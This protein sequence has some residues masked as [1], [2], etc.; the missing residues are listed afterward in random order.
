MGKMSRNKGARSERAL[1]D[2][3]IRRNWTNVIRV[4][5][6]GAVKTRDA[7][8]DDVVGTPPGW[9]SEIRFENKA[10]S[11]GFESIYALLNSKTTLISFSVHNHIVAVMS[12][13]PTEI[14]HSASKEGAPD[15]STFDI[16]TQKV[17]K[18][19]IKK[20]EMWIGTAQVLSLKLDRHPFLFIRYYR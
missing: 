7:Y 9:D 13:D 14:L 1:R 2:E 10:R 8:Q 4:P 5:L 12:L 19:V 20:C 16:K 18:Q 6:S 3:L 17:L 11:K 15:I